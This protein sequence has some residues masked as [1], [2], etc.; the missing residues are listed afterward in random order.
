MCVDFHAL[1]KVMIR[2]NY[3]LPLI[4][5]QLDMLRK[6]CFFSKLDLKDGF[7]SHSHDA[8]GSKIYLVRDTSGAIRVF[9][10]AIRI[11]NWPAIP[12]VY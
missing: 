1:N 8:G 3:P 9:E 6:K 2:N 5:D 7:L 11:K 10:N 12:A 4:E